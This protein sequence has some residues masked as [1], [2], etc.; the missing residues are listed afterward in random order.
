MK[1]PKKVTLKKSVVLL[2]IFV[3][4]LNIKNVSN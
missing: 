1:T 3:I 4:N 2:V